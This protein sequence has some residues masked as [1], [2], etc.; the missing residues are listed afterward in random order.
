MPSNVSTAGLALY[1]AAVVAAL[2]ALFFRIETVLSAVSRP[3][4]HVG[5]LAVRIDDIESSLD[6]LRSDVQSLARTVDDSAQAIDQ[7]TL[8][9]TR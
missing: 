8:T 7:H 2:V 3:S 6:D 5:G 1:R 9:C 4:L